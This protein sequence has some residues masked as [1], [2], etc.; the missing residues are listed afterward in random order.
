[1]IVQSKDP[2]LS[3]QTTTALAGCARSPAIRLVSE[4]DAPA[5]PPQTNEFAGSERRLIIR[6]E[7]YWLSLRRC[8][9]GPF[10]EDFHPLRNPVPWQN[11]LIAHLD[12]ENAEP[13]FDHVGASVVALLKPDR[14]NLPDREWLI[15]AVTLHLGKMNDALV[16]ARPVKREGSFERPRGDVA[17]Y[18]SLLLPFVDLRRTP[19]YVLGAVTYRLQDSMAA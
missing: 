5:A 10:F 8:A 2:G 14:T 18:R 9:Q 19:T 17:L 1:M 13:A 15:D 16:T 6:L 7:D 11:C 3:G 4:N 12:G